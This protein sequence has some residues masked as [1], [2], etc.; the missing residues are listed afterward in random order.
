M[1][2]GLLAQTADEDSRRVL[3]V[4]EVT[5]QIVRAEQLGFD[6][7]WVADHLFIETPTGRVTGH[8][9]M[10]HLAHAAART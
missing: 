1:R 7:A 2:V 3:G 5:G 6:S 9:P 10:V 4:E 8:D